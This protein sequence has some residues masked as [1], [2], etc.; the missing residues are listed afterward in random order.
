[1]IYYSAAFE[2]KQNG[3]P[4]V[5]LRHLFVRRG[6][7][8]FSAAKSISTLHQG[9]LVVDITG[10]AIPATA[11]QSLKSQYGI[12]QRIT[13][14]LNL[15]TLKASG[16]AA[17]YL[18]IQTLML[19]AGPNNLDSQSRLHYLRLLLIRLV[20]FCLIFIMVIILPFLLVKAWSLTTQKLFI[21]SSCALFL[22]IAAIYLSS[23]FG[24]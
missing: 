16:L 14:P 8:V 20:P 1:M 10:Y 9:E 21:F 22:L 6:H 3:S 18:D 24:R 13:L 4:T 23:R 19:L 11:S 17:R 5:L 12:P 15:H 7:T 2:Y